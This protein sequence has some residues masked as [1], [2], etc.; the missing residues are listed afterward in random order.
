MS[1]KPISRIVNFVRKNFTTPQLRMLLTRHILSRFSLLRKNY[2]CYGSVVDAR[3]ACRRILF[4]D[5]FDEVIPLT[6]T[7]RDYYARYEGRGSNPISE[8]GIF[9]RYDNNILELADCQIL[10]K[11][12]AILHIPSECL[13]VSNASKISRGMARPFRYKGVVHVPG[14][15]VSLMSYPRG[16]AHYFHFLFDTLKPFIAGCQRVPE[17]RSAT[18]LTRKNLAH[19]QEVTLRAL[20]EKYPGLI[21]RAMPDDVRIECERLLYPEPGVGLGVAAFGDR[22]TLL[23]IGSMLREAAGADGISPHKRLFISR[24]KQRMRKLTNEDKIFAML[25]PMGFERIAPETLPFEEQIRAFASAEIIVGASGAALTNL[26]FCSPGA[27][28]IEMC[29][30]DVHRHLW[31][32]LA[33]QTGLNHYFVPGSEGGL[34]A[35]FSVDVDA[36]SRTVR[37]AADRY[38]K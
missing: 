7:E 8:E 9:F 38:K 19:H 22:A 32:L 26:L 24:K 29:P 17:F 35:G 33:R 13:V 3:R 20:H 34:Y 14:L 4:S 18:I 25:E 27:T 1:R 37:G 23:E 28:I 15:C 5:G 11:S 10:P 31:I 36:L 16:H 6:G 21:I 30:A 12:A 2:A